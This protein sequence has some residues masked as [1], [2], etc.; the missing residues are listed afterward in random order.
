MNNTL[1]TYLCSAEELNLA[2]TFECGQC[3]RWNANEKGGYS[4]VALGKY[5]ELWE[6]NSDIF[7]S[8]SPEEAQKIWRDY[9]DLDLDYLSITSGF[10][11]EYIQKCAEF[12][13]GIRI[14]KQDFWETLASFIFSQCNNIPRI[15]KIVETFARE[16]GEK[17][18]SGDAIFYTFP[19]YKTISKLTEK[20][21]APLHCGYRAKYIL[22]AAK[23]LESGEICE[24]HLKTLPADYM[25]FELKKISGVG[26]K[27]ADCVI[28][29]GLHNMSAFPIDVWMKRALIENFPKNFNPASFGEYAGLAQQYIFNYARN[30]GEE[31]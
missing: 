3:F 23:M 12:G 30:K 7:C 6:E 11:G 8:A 10:R 28:L 22:S 5:L 20:D 17:K 4:G 29:F 16:H 14:L 27:V 1:K 26:D 24:A 18:T 2:K 15:K 19:S 13:R 25:R 31:N 9:F 21:L